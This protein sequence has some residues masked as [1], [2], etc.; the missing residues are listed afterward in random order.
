MS[1][2]EAVELERA[3]LEAAWDAKHP[4]GMFLLQVLKRE[5]RTPHAVNKIVAE[6]LTSRP[7]S[8]TRASHGLILGVDGIQR[9]WV[10]SARYNRVEHTSFANLKLALEEICFPVEDIKALE[11]WYKQR[12]PNA[13]Y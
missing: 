1:V 2:K 7:T 8:G 3:K 4:N 13:R 11:D 5:Y 6:V 10:L 9:P 12:Y